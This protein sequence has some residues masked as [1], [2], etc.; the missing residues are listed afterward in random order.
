M[1]YVYINSEPGLWTVG[2]YDP[3]DNWQPESDHESR[4]QAAKRVAWLNGSSR[5]LPE[6]INQALNEGDGVYRP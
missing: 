6:H 4:E 3:S 1:S 5:G 2:F